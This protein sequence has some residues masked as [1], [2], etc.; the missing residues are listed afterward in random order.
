VGRK[1]LNNFILFPHQDKAIKES[2]LYS[3]RLVY[4]LPGTGKTLIGAELI[5]KTLSRKKGAYTLWIG[6]AN[7]SP[8]YKDSFDKYGLPSY[9]YDAKNR[10][11]VTEF[12][13]I[14]S[15]ETFRLYIDK[16]LQI[17]W[18]CVICDEV[19]RAKS[20]KAQI[21]S[22]IKK[23]RA[24][25]KQFY[26]LTGTPF[27]NTPYEFFEL[28]SLIAGR[29]LSFACEE[30]LQYMRPR[31]RFFQKILNFFR[32]KTKRINQGPIIGVKEPEKLRSLISKYID[33][34]PPEK[35]ISQCHLP[36]VIEKNIF[37]NISES[38]LIFYKKI[39]KKYKKIKYKEFFDDCLSENNIDPVFNE[40][41]ELRQALID[42]YGV[43]SSKILKCVE[44]IQNIL[45]QKTEKVIVFCNFV[46]RGLF[47]LSNILSEKNI[48]HRL[49]CGN[50][51]CRERQI[52]ISSYLAGE[53]QVLLL[54]PVGFEGL[55]LY[56]TTDILVIDPHFNPE[57]Q[58][59]LISRAIRAYS[60]VDVIN[61]TNYISVSEIFG[62]PTVDESILKIAKRKKYL[63]DIIERNLLCCN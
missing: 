57:R 41:T 2:D 16:F 9:C 3:C 62:A 7:L 32:I 25:S 56:G 34:I 49:I 6:P 35:Y 63:I 46:E 5:K 31:K 30:T 20:P 58:L 39:L 10:N 54:S 43:T 51:S 60:N 61:I 52:I 13:I 14:V 22:A 27:Q 1:V 17:S 28:I 40:L 38:E 4:R 15:Y 45:K 55:D 21:N 19:H 8:Q 44:E 33:Y 18:D 37:V 29:N 53:N 26:G 59:Q 36:K 11:I 42:P 50:T 12:C 48:S 23:I 24:K 47:V